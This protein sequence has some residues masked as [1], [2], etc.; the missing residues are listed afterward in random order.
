MMRSLGLGLIVVMTSFGIARADIDIAKS[1]AAFEEGLK[2]KDAGKL[3]A[4]CMK[5]KDALKFN[6]NAVGTMLN[7][8]VCDEQ[9]GHIASA[10]KRFKE[11]RDRGRE[12]N[13][14]EQVKLAEQHIAQLEPDMPYLAIAFAETT[15]DTKL[16]VNDEDISVK[17]AGGIPV[18]PGQVSIVVS[19][20][21]R[22]PFETKVDISK[23]EHKAVAVPKLGLP[24]TVNKGR[25]R[26][27]EI[28]TIAGGA[29]VVAG[30]TLGIVARSKY[31]NQF[32]G[33]MPHC[34]KSTSGPPTCDAMGQPE[35]DSARTIGNFGT[36][37]GIG[38]V[39]IAGIGAYLWFFGPH[40]E[41]LAIG[42]D[43]DSQHAG[44]VA[45]GRW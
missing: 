25:R 1:D 40:D 12:Q 6:P 2:L 15:D 27:G 37:F 32:S 10:Y 43:V 19:R 7:V 11:A 23:K 18:D 28:I 17:D 30:I 31:N 9:T 39:V 13:L 36:G 44:I 3:D 24:V 21:G 41:K 4:A 33:S 14:G 38:G 16:L 26:I 22:V 8:A 35:T 5:F 29:S 42:P 45:V 34:T 20:P